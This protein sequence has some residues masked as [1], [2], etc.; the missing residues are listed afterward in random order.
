M[1]CFFFPVMYAAFPQ[2][3]NTYQQID[4]VKVDKIMNANIP[5]H[6]GCTVWR[7]AENLAVLNITGLGQ[8]YAVLGSSQRN[9][10]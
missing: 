3:L 5:R 10:K 7:A 9:D 1:T 6:R 2:C 8:T 4:L